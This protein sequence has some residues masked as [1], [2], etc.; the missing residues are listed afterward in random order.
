L[1]EQ[2]LGGVEDLVALIGAADLPRGPSR[3]IA[4][5]SGW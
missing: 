1:R 5:F 3:S 2:R 4:L